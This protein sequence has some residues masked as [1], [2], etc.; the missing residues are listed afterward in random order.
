MANLEGRT[1]IVTGG[2]HGVGRGIAIALADA[3]AKVVVCG[4]TPATLAAVRSEIEARGGQAQDVVCDITRKADLQRLVEATLARFGA[5]N[6]LVNNAALVPHGSLLEI[7][8]GL[9]QGAW[10]AGPLASLQ[11]MR[12]CHPHLKGDGAIVN[13]SSGSSIAA[14]V[15]LRGIYAAVKAALNA[16]SR[17]A[18]NEWGPD[19][20]RVNT[21]MPIALTEPFERF[22]A[23]EPE[24]AAAAVAG[25]P[26]GRIGDCVEDIGRA[27]VFLCGPDARYLTGAILPRDGGAGYIR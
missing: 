21:I 25:I 14:N 19:G 1:A 27:V 13:V 8:D 22:M 12:L 24:R 18:A 16:I 23:N 11:L 26:L 15:P 3:G 4:R 5:I 9:I 17:A 7:D 2:G 20:I 6:I 10:E